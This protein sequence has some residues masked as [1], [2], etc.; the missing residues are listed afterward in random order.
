M[1]KVV[2]DDLAD[3]LRKGIICTGIVIL[4]WFIGTALE[5]I[6]YS[7]P[8]DAIRKNISRGIMVYGAETDFYMYAEDYLSTMKDNDSDS[9]IL[10][11]TAYATGHPLHD[12]MAS[13]YPGRNE[14]RVNNIIAWS[15]FHNDDYAIADY[16]RYWHGY[17]TIF[18]PLFYFFSFAD[19]RVIKYIIELTIYGL[20]GALIIGN[21]NLGREYAIAYLALLVILNPIIISLAFQYMPCTYIAL[22]TTIIILKY[23]VKVDEER[24]VYIMLLSGILTSFFDFLTFPLITLGVPL[25][26]TLIYDC[27][28]REKIK[29]MIGASMAW[30]FGYLGMWSGK[31]IL[32]SMILGEDVI[33]QA[34]KYV[35]HR[36]GAVTPDTTR[37]N[38][39]Y[40]VA[41][42]LIKR[43]Y[44]IFFFAVTVYLFI[45]YVLPAIKNK[46][47][48]D[49]LKQFM[50]FA[51]LALY[52]LL[53]IAATFQHC[54]ENQK[55]TYRNLSVMAF[56]LVIGIIYSGKNV[57]SE[58][59]VAEE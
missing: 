35:E 30:S 44:V 9:V 23:N 24:L 3:L 11:E 53:W 28:V 12:A 22:I 17:V 16:S 56:A 54:Y 7:I 49:M 20:L 42:V 43:P 8:T 57:L 37:L 32:S 6:V 2:F 40:S 36:T 48:L 41:R 25:T 10:C 26:V 4:A 47:S 55:F 46:R 19:M 38:A 58:M 5:T 18:K 51:I 34:I 45:K 39:V 33:A 1:K 59:N 50:P 14:S 15:F 52:G 27:G 31:W 21:T 13:A 29:H